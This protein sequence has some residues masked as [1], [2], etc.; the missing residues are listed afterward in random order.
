MND[1]TVLVVGG[2]GYIGAHMVN[3]LL[4]ANVGVIT[5]DNLSTGHRDLH[6][7]GPLIEGRLG[8]A[9][10]LDKIFSTHDIA[11]VMHFAAYSLVGESV[12]DP[13]KYYRNNLAETTELLDA[14]RRHKVKRFIFSSSAAVYGEPT[15]VPISEEHPCAPT[16]PYG[17][18]KLAV[19][20]ML[21][22]CD[23]AH[24]LKFLALRYFNAAGADESGKLGERHEPETHL[25]PLI[26]KVATAERKHVKIFGTRYP[27]PD[28]TC[29]RDYIHVTDLADAH[30]R[31][32]DA[33]LDGGASGVWN[34]GT[35]RGHSNREVLA[36]VERTVG[37]PVPVRDAPRRPGDPPQLVADARRFQE[38]FGW[39]P[40]HSDLETIVG[41][42]WAWLRSW[43]GAS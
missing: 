35:G 20:R 39:R 42:A 5:L 24:N 19:E 28:G 43:K 10:L 23:T 14:M 8:D 29:I 17:A 30:V 4:K 38:T 40:H 33:L 37:R 2:A 34:L 18:T 12:A 16:N 6:P 9:A 26:L 1:Y 11:A 3:E 15:Q 22:D 25:I 32:L 27:T 31:S 13:L 36:A 41:T 21:Q 7:G